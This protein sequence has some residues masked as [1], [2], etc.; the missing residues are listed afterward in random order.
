M[1][2]NF[3][4]KKTETESKPK[5]VK[6][7]PTKSEE[8]PALMIS[9]GE[10]SRPK[11]KTT[12]KKTVKGPHVEILKFDFDPANPKIGSLEL[13]WNKEFIKLL[14][15][16]GYRG[17]SDEE[18]VDKWLNDVCRN[19]ALSSSDIMQD[20]IRYIQRKDLGDGKTEFS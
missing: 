7:E 10:H 16:H 4:N 9:Q 17:N 19:I 1:I 13:D 12:K 11:K 15:E 18:L 20:N 6:Q 5:K 14:I 3:F 2:W 8:V